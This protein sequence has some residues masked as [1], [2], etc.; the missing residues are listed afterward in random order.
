MSAKL[1]FLLLSW[2]ILDCNAA[3]AH[4]HSANLHKEREDDG[5]YSPRSKS[6]S[7]ETKQEFDHEAILGS[8]KEAEMFDNMSPEE[9]KRRLRILLTKMDLNKDMLISKLE[10]TEW[11][12]KSFKSLSEE[13]AKESLEDVDENA[14]G[15]ATWDEYVTNTYD[16]EDSDMELDN[17][18]LIESDR[19]MW[20]VADKNNDG[21]LQ[22]EEWIAFSHPE[23]HERMFQVILA[24]TLKQ[25]DVD[26]DESISFQEF[27]GD[28]D[29]S[30]NKEWL[31]AEKEKF[32]FELDQNRDGKLTGNEIIAW[33]V[34]NNLEIAE[35]EVEHLFAS[36]DDDHDEILS[37]DEI[38]E[39]HEIFVG[40]EVTDY[41]DHLHNLHHFDDEL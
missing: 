24:Q 2:F 39:H 6:P 40:S 26:N 4:L 37:F 7:G 34:P 36:S 35:E 21:V 29:K 31:Q 18:Q 28:S 8:A 32:D 13:E 15:K 22:G 11:I 41:G 12:I 10:L 3:V 38:I 27:V 30:N 17:E 14:D 9:S 23:E 1:V 33:V 20:L 19:G 16:S 25:K 5:A